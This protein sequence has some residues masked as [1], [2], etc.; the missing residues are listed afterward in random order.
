MEFVCSEVRG[1]FSDYM[2]RGNLI[3]DLRL[4]P[5]DLSF[6]DPL[7]FLSEESRFDSAVLTFVYLLFINKL[8]IKQR[9]F[10]F[11]L[12]IFMILPDPVFH[13]FNK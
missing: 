12:K 7:L 1:S 3:S 8:L 6:M 13:D 10:S 5:S 2:I 9:L 11:S 4:R